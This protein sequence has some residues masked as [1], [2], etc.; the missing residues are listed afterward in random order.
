MKIKIIKNKHFYKINQFKIQLKMIKTIYNSM[1]L[2]K[3][4]NHCNKIK[5]LIKIKTYNKIIMIIK[6]IRN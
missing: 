5:K 1:I 2:F 3:I 4:K 6:K